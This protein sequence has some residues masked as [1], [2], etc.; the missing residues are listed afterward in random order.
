MQ[1]DVHLFETDTH[2]VYKLI[3]VWC[4]WTVI[5]RIEWRCIL[6]RLL[7]SSNI[8]VVHNCTVII[9]CQKIGAF[10]KVNVFYTWK[11]IFNAAFKNVHVYMKKLESTE[12][13]YYLCQLPPWGQKQEKGSSNS[14]TKNKEQKER[15]GMTLWRY[16]RGKLLLCYFRTQTFLLQSR[17]QF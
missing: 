4:L 2:L 11:Q 16:N 3:N 1:C 15:L 8:T 12:T 14:L 10:H 13:I 7:I 6:L 9:C 5:F 17:G